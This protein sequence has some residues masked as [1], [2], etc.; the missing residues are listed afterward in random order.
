LFTHKPVL[1]GIADI[2]TLKAISALVGDIDVRVSSATIT[3]GLFPRQSS[4]TWSV[5][6]QSMLP[7]DAVARGRPGAA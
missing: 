7:V 4:T 1:A 6:R 3:R 2:P 5:R